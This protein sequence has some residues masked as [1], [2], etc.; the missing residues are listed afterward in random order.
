[1]LPDVAFTQSRDSLYLFNTIPIL[2]SWLEVF[3]LKPYK[4]SSLYDLHTKKIAVLQGA[5]QEQFIQPFLKKIGVDVE[6]VPFPT[7]ESS[8][9]ALQDGT[10]DVLLASRFFYF[11][12]LYN[13]SIL[14]TSHVF[15]PTQLHVAFRQ[16]F[17]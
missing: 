16:D 4:I 6:I 11:S 5:I 1:M 8:V 17:D 2:E 13:P 15:N 10:V 7:Y 3:V 12:D 14:S 9:C